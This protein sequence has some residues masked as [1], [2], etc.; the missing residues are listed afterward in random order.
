MSKHVSERMSAVI[1]RLWQTQTSRALNR[2]ARCSSLRALK[3]FAASIVHRRS[4]LALNA[5]SSGAAAFVQLHAR[6]RRVACAVRLS[7]QRKALNGWMAMAA[8]RGRSRRRLEAA[9]MGGAAGGG[10]RRGRRGSTSCTVDG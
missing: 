4:R 8:V 2:G 6:V 3:R 10:G 5:W 1:I 7:S 9:A